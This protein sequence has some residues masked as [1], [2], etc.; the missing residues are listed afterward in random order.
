MPDELATRLT[1]LLTVGIVACLG[2]GAALSWI[3]RRT[4]GPQHAADA[5]LFVG[6]SLFAA[7]MVWTC[8]DMAAVVWERRH[9]AVVRGEML[10][11]EAVTLRTSPSGRKLKGVAPAV[12]FRAADGKLVVVHGLSGSQRH[13]EPGST[14]WVRV[15]PQD[16]TRSVIAD[17]QNQY[18]AL[19][20]VGTITAVVVLMALSHPLRWW[21]GPVSPGYA[22]W[23]DAAQRQRWHGQFKR[24]AAA[25]LAA[26]ILGIFLLA[27]MVDIGRAFA[28]GLFGVALAM[29][30]A[31]MAAM[32]ERGKGSVLALGGWAIGSL[33]LAGF[34]GLL[35]QLSGP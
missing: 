19:W 31:G 22:H 26:S 27:E 25:T 13:R 12:Q 34:G 5:G 14:V 23:R 6:L 15:H 8:W 3:W 10:G 17:F 21:L 32:L 35:W 28:G 29:L 16:H 18:A 1:L 9:H 11:A 7:G 2:L 20:L 24:L 4:A 30:Q 33:A